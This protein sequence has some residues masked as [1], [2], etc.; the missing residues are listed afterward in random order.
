MTFSYLQNLKRND[1]FFCLVLF[2]LYTPVNFHY[3]IIEKIDFINFILRTSFIL[4]LFIY[5]KYENFL[6]ND[7]N[8]FKPVFFCFKYL[9]Y[10]CLFLGFLFEVSPYLRKTLCSKKQKVISFLLQKPFSES[11]LIRFENSWFYRMENAENFKQD[12]Y[13]CNFNQKINPLL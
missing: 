7:S 11:I 12:Q 4:C 8:L 2:L 6:T 9:F 13:N 10:I 3:F 1:L 5:L